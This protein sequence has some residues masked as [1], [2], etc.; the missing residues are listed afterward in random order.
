MSPD[1]SGDAYIAQFPNKDH[2]YKER[3]GT[4]LRKVT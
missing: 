1:F 4:D 3:V 2:A